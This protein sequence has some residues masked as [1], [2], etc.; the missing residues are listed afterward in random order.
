MTTE[1]SIIW[2][3]ISTS[4]KMKVGAHEPIGWAGDGGRLPGLSFSAG[5][6]LKVEILLTWDDLYDVKVYR[7]RDLLR[8]V[9]QPVYEIEGA[10]FDMLDDILSE[11]ADK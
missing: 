2:S 4:V 3:Q 7:R 6:Y 11:H 1:A 5:R 10:Y 9:Q 8:G